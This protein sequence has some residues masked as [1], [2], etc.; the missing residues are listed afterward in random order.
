MATAVFKDYFSAKAAK[1]AASRPVYPRALID[2]LADVAPGHGQALDCG[3]GNGQLSTQLA[4]RFKRVIA[5]DASAEQIAN[6]VPHESVVYRVAPA[7]QSGLPAGSVDL[8]TVAQA[9]HWLDLNAFYAEVR[10]V[11]RANA[12]V[13]LIAYDILRVEDAEANAAIQRFC[14]ET[15]RPYWPPERRHVDEG[16]RSLPFPFAEI[17]APQFVM[18]ATWGMEDL[19]GYIETWSAVSTAEKVAGR[20]PMDHFR[21][22]LTRIWGPPATKRSMR[23]PLSLRVGR[24]ER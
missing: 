22:E 6:A 4:R 5:T 21:A 2:F 9:A 14:Y 12:I 7:E 24:V 18:E 13:A 15:M 23:W 8:V 17:E 1:Y 19:L 20:E 11:A 3:C 16:Y 10:R